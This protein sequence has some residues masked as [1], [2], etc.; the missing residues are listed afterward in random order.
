MHKKSRFSVPDLSESQKAVG[1][2]PV[3]PVLSAYIGLETVHGWNPPVA[4]QL[5]NVVTNRSIHDLSG[6]LL[7]PSHGT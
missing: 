5:K 1:I 4:L 3:Y 6:C 2:N 7:L